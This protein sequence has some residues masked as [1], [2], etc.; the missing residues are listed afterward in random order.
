MN[1]LQAF[2]KNYGA[3]IFQLPAVVQERDPPITKAQIEEISGGGM[4]KK[5]K[6]Y[7]KKRRNTRRNTRRKN[8]INTKKHSRG[9]KHMGRKS[10]TGGQPNINKL[11]IL[12]ALLSLIFQPVAGAVESSADAGESP[13]PETTT[14]QCIVAVFVIMGVLNGLKYAQ[15]GDLKPPT[16]WNDRSFEMMVGRNVDDAYNRMVEGGEAILQL[17]EGNRY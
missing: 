10:Q 17:L 12:V 11:A 14:T 9:K 15:G 5:S 6:L 3:E 1:Q 8:N 4:K 16:T 7:K 2:M 13:A